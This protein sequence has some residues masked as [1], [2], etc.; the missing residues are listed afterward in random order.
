MRQCFVIAK[1]CKK[2]VTNIN[3][4]LKVPNINLQNEIKI[5]L[6]QKT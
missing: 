4:K 2:T 1:K 6:K 3:L 5:E